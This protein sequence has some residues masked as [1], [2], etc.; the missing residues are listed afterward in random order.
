MKS[1]IDPRLI[2]TNCIARDPYYGTY[3]GIIKGSRKNY[4]DTPRVN[5]LIVECIEPPS[6]DAIFYKNSRVNRKP[7]PPGS[8][9][10]FAI[11]EVTPMLEVTA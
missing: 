7:Y 5:V 4:T 1:S 9:Q 6:Q 2:G 8:T 11:T 3:K 10:H